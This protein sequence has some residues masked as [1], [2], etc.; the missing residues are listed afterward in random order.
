MFSDPAALVLIAGA[1]AMAAIPATWLALRRRRADGSAAALPSTITITMTRDSVCMA[2]DID[3]PHD[4]TFAV[5]AAD[6]LADI[7]AR[8]AA[9]SYLLMPSDAWGWT[10]EADGAVVAIRTGFVRHRVTTLRGDPA[11]VMAHD[12]PALSAL[13]VRPGSPWCDVAPTGS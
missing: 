9:S 4:E 12:H 8:V 7:A 5:T 13:Y 3:S 1:L 11:A 10:I 2:D 6:T